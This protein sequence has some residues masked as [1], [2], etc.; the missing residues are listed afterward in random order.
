MSVETVDRAQQLSYQAVVSKYPD[1]SRFVILKADVQRRGVVYT[2]RALAQADPERHLM[3]ARSIFHSIGEKN[4]QVPVSLLLR[5]G[6]S[7]VTGPRPDAEAPYTV[8]LLDGR[9]VLTDEGRILEE[10]EYW[11]KPDFVSQFT[12]SGRPMWQVA[13]PRPQRMDINPY[14]YCHYWDDG[15]GCKY[16]NIAAHYN[17]E[18][19][20][21]QKPLRLD[22]REVSETVGAAIRQ[23]G[24]FTTI[25]LTCGS[26]LGDGEL[27]A[28][29]VD[30]YIETLQAIGENFST[31]RFPSQL[32]ASAFS[33][34]QLARVHEQTG[35]LTY[36]SNIEVLSEEKFNWICPGKAARP[37]YREWKRRLV[38]AVEIFGAGNVNTG[39]VGGVELATPHGFLSEDEG[40]QA[41]LEEAEDLASQGVA[42]V[43][44]VWVP[45][46]GSVFHKQKAPSLEY[47]VRLALGLDGLRRRYGLLVDMDSYRICGNHPDTDL[48]R[49]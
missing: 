35:L 4:D 9:V 32:V 10:V 2:E 34:E 28:A 11:P 38:Q 33:P 26:I 1:V 25:G 5:D 20:T 24:R 3:Q 45:V 17:K 18:R 36:T 41:T 29:E 46:A 37:G 27:F 31:R 7:I 23:P 48:S 19:K 14:A 16:C 39:I 15:K 40:L 49:I 44:C 6:T 22:P 30:I 12:S 13:T 8:D 21:H 42:T 47:Y 43:S